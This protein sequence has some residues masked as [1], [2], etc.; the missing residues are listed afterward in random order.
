[1]NNIYRFILLYGAFLVYS[2]VAVLAKIAAKQSSLIA[3]AVF[4]GCEIICL[5]IY[6]LLWQQVLKRFSLITAIANKGCV[7]IYNLFWAWLL[8]NELITLT[9][10]VGSIII[11]FGIILVSQ[12]E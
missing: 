2:L 1:M 6:A 4:A 5:G 12:D 8:F 9:N 7:I 10:I 11:V 3:T